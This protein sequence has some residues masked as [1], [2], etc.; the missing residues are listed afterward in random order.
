MNL[1]Q[2]L[3]NLI[4]R[5]DAELERRN[6]VTLI[7]VVY[8]TAEQTFDG[9]QVISPATP[10]RPKALRRQLPASAASPLA[11]PYW[12]FRPE[13]HKLLVAILH[14]LPFSLKSPFLHHQASIHSYNRNCCCAS[15][16]TAPTTG[17]TSPGMSGGAKAGLALG[18]LLLIGVV[19]AAILFLFRQRK[20]KYDEHDRLDDEKAFLAGGRNPNALPSHA[21]PDNGFPPTASFDTSQTSVQRSTA[22]PSPII[23]L[24]SLWLQLQLQLQ[25]PASS[26]SPNS[27]TMHDSAP[28]LSLRAVSQFEPGLPLAVVVPFPLCLHM[29]MPLPVPLLQELLLLPAPLLS[30]AMHPRTA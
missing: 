17:T 2:A 18:I 12:W 19:L 6:V 29:L 20:R 28:Q 22:L 27:G 10:L 26:L 9:Q 7:S 30:I 14:Q 5:D 3:G 4:R 21:T 25:L 13:L 8:S 15:T 24:P 1:L 11:S 23:P 16:S